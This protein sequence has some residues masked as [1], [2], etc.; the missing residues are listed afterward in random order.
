MS[1]YGTYANKAPKSD[2]FDNTY[3]SQGRIQDFWKGGSYV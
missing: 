1:F 2:I 3:E